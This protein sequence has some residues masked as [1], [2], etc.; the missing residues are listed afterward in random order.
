MGLTPYPVTRS[1]S[2]SENNDSKMWHVLLG[3]Y[4]YTLATGT[5][6]SVNIVWVMVKPIGWKGG[7]AAYP[8]LKFTVDIHL[9]F[10]CSTTLHY[11]SH[12]SQCFG[13]AKTL[14]KLSHMC[15]LLSC[16]WIW[17]CLY[18][19]I[20]EFT[21]MLCTR[22]QFWLSLS[23]LPNVLLSDLFL[24]LRSP[25]P[26]HFL[27]SWTLLVLFSR[28]PTEFHSSCPHAYTDTP[29]SVCMETL[30][31]RKLIKQRNVNFVWVWVTLMEK[32]NFLNPPV[33]RNST[34]YIW[35]IFIIHSSGDGCL[36]P[37]LSTEGHGCA[38]VSAIR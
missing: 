18:I 32:K 19:L 38:C 16:F 37:C 3:E 24:S 35:P 9:Y 8:L 7:C 21:V 4:I 2:I 20:L 6:T 34:V 30:K 23:F 26:P 11:S 33:F 14:V 29:L 36:F 22:I 1:L 13:L 5:C 25:V 10:E 17:F 28:S 27:T 12:I 15:S 31:V